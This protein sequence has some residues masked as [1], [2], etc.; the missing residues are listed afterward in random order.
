VS[1]REDRRR[2]RTDRAE[3]EQDAASEA[4]AKAMVAN[5]KWE[6]ADTARKARGR[7]ARLREAWRGR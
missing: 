6:A 4:H 3:G 1:T 2:H 5:Q 7:W